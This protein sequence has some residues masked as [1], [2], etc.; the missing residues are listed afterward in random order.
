MANPMQTPEH[1]PLGDQHCAALDKVLSNSAKG[2]ALA[3]DCIDCGLD[4]QQQH[5][6]LTAQQQMAQKLKAKF[7][8]N[9]S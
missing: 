2:I 3:K 1:C 4:Y 7:F 6:M 9:R 5:D 8:P